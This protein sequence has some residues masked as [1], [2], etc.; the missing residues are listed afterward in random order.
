[1]V[2]NLAGRLLT[3]L[4]PSSCRLCASPGQGDL[5]LCPDCLADLPRLENACQRCARPLAA[6][7]DQCICGQCQQNPPPFQRT[8]AI[9]HYAPPVDFLVQQLKFHADLSTARLLGSLLASHIAAGSS[10]MP[11]LLLPVPLHRSRQAQRGFNQ[12]LEIART[13]GR[14]LNIAVST[15]HCS[16]LRPTAS[17]SLLPLTARRTNLHGA[18]QARPPLGS[19]HVAIIDDVM[20]T[21]ETV[22]E[23]AQALHQAGAIRVDVWVVARAG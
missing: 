21:G 4:F 20:T 18:F 23:L 14:R 15:R 10:P 11:D 2:Y 1:M 8:K 9:F 6:D 3:A 12:A 16:R 13:T 19:P 17:Q 22:R 5:D 7:S